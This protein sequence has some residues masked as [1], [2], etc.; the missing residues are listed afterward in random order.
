MPRLRRQRNEAIR[1]GEAAPELDIP[2]PRVRLN[3]A[4][5]LKH[6]H[7]DPDTGRCCLPISQRR[8]RAPTKNE[9]CARAPKRRSKAA[10]TPPP[11]NV[12]FALAERDREK[13]GSRIRQRRI[14]EFARQRAQTDRN[15]TS[16]DA[17]S[18]G[19]KF[20]P[21]VDQRSAFGRRAQNLL[22]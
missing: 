17:V 22:L 14:E 7:R 15:P 21:A 20:L 9:L 2:A 16:A 3:P 11:R 4:E 5:N 1:D 12:A 8:G 10:A 19:R 13:D 6:L 18:N